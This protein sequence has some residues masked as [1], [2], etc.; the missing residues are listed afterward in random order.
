MEGRRVGGA[1][2]G[3]SAGGRGCACTAVGSAE[4]WALRLVPERA[5]PPPPPLPPARR[6]VHAPNSRRKTLCG[7]L[8]YLPPEM[9]EGNYHDAAVDVWSLVG[10]LPLPLPLPLPADAAAG[11]HF[12]WQ[13]RQRR[14]SRLGAG[15]GHH[16][17]GLICLVCSVAVPRRWFSVH[18]P[19]PSRVPQPLARPLAPPL[20]H[21][22]ACRACCATSSCMASRRLRPRG[23]ARPTSASCASTSASRPPPS[24]ATAPRT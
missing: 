11:T 14:R 23:T 2:E 21:P 22:A 18:S 16:E 9:V 1:R 8:D 24:A 7:T 13:A 15:W 4:Q 10:G 5:P 6:S 20:L 3:R 12:C 17:A 19:A